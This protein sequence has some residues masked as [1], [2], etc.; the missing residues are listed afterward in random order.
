MSRK[1]WRAALRMPVPGP[2]AALKT[3][4]ERIA[5]SV[6]WRFAGDSEHFN[7][8]HFNTGDSEHFNTAAVAEWLARRTR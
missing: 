3:Q 6:E 8:E 1:M 5:S 2:S 4:W 7:S